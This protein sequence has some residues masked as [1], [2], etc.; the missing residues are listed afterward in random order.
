[1]TPPMEIGALNR[2]GHPPSADGLRALLRRHGEFPAQHRL[3]V[4][5]ALLQLPRN[6]SAHK[7]LLAR[8]PHNVSAQ[9]QC[10]LPLADR[11]GLSRLERLHS[12]LTHWCPFLAQVPQLESTIHPWLVAFGAD[13]LGAF[14]ATATVLANWCA[15]F[16][17]CHPHPPVEL[18]AGIDRLLHHHCPALHAHLVRIGA[19]PADWAW[20]LLESL[21]SRVLCRADWLVVWD[22][23][24]AHEPVFL[25]FVLIAFV[26]MHSGTLLLVRDVIEL[27]C[28]LFRQSALQIRPWLRCAREMHG[29]TPEELVPTMGLFSALPPGPTYPI[30]IDAPL[31]VV[32]FGRREVERIR[33]HELELLRRKAASPTLEPGSPDVVFWQQGLEDDAAHR[34]AD[35][36]R[37]A[38]YPYADA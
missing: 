11:R 15:R 14:E 25:L 22:H 9:L 37:A 32:D 20:P 6:A 38:A 23:V 7:A 1:M 18:L 21:F 12:C 29:R 2:L 33:A 36:S 30:L 24:L 34:P 31:A 19:G 28:V 10:R 4:W 16:Y 8:G 26:R 13:T 17:E 35:A 27:E 5:R 3:T